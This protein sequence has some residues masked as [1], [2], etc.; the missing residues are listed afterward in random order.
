[1]LDIPSRV[2]R[3]LRPPV[4]WLACRQLATITTIMAVPKAAMHKDDLPTCWKDE[5]WR[6]G[7]VAPVQA[8]AVAHCVDN[9]AHDELRLGVYFPDARH[10]LGERELALYRHHYRV[11]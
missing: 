7:Q 5:V 11:S 9:S 6:A 4:V 3:E 2:S 8:V 1:M 10:A